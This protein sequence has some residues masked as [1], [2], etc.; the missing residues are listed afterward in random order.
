MTGVTFSNEELAK[1]KEIYEA[2][3]QAKA[4]DVQNGEVVMSFNHLG[5][6]MS[7]KVNFVAYR[8]G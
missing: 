5:H 2:L 3:I 4:F 1:H 8:K 7:V 6:L